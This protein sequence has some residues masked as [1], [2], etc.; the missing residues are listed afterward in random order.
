MFRADESH[1]G[2][3]AA[4]G[5]ALEKA[6]SVVFGNRQGEGAIGLAMLDEVVEIFLHVGRPGGSEQAAVSQGARA[7][8]GGSLKPG[9]DFSGLQ[10]ANCGGDFVVVRV[11]PAIGSLAVVEDL[12]D[13]FAGKTGPPVQAEFG[14]DAR[15]LFDAMPGQPG[16]AER[17]A[18]VSCGGLNEDLIEAGLFFDGGNDEWI[19]KEAAGE[20]QMPGAGF[21][22][23][24]FEKFEHHGGARALHAGSKIRAYALFD[25]SFCGPRRFQALVKLVG[26]SELARISAAEEFRIQMR[27][28]TFP[29][30]EH[31]QEQI[32]KPRLAGER[33]PLGFVLV[34]A[35][36]ETEQLGDLGVDPRQG[37]RKAN[38]VQ[39]ANSAALAESSQSA[40]AIAQFIE[41]KDQGAIE[42]R[43]VESAGGVAGGVVELQQVPARR[44][45]EKIED[46]QIIEFAG[47]LTQSFALIVAAGNGR[48][49]GHAGAKESL[50]RPG[51]E[52]TA[53][54]GDVGNVLPANPGFG[55][56]VGDG[57]ARNSLAMALP[58]EFSF[59]ERV[60]DSA[61][62]EKRGGRV[63]RQRRDAQDVHIYETARWSLLQKAAAAATGHNPR[64]AER[65]RKNTIRR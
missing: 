50:T 42:R 40:A 5:R 20:A 33:Q 4:C 46:A 39:L 3:E 22:T 41:R 65:R 63:V 15:F 51:A 17:G 18:F 14:S 25:W 10:Q 47:E 28:G 58:Q 60:D 43:G 27:P 19:Q 7:K 6:R 38:R 8:F 13:L 21:L 53:A 45:L 1:G 62:A 36:G 56:A 61:F 30:A 59:F 31:F 23:E 26:E 32:P 48:T 2:H 44:A 35:R 12:F 49:Q 34:G 11:G 16:C 64:V 57:L 29:G 37:V 54:D 9:H 24:A 52:R 55:E